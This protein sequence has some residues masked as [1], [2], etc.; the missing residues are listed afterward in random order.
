[1]NRDSL[2]AYLND[3]LAIDNF[4]DY[5]VNGLQVEGKP[6]VL[7]IAGGVSVS[8]RFIH[9]AIDWGADL[10]LLHHGLFWKSDPYPFYLRGIQKRRLELLIKND[11]NLVAYHLPLDAHDRLG[12]NIQIL[13]KLDLRPVEPLEVGFIGT[14]REPLSRDAF[15]A[16][17]NQKLMCDAAPF[18]YGPDAIQT[19]LVI[20]GASSAAYQEAAA[21]GV[22][23]FV[24]G[25]IREENVR[26]IEEVQLNYIAAGHYNTERFGVQALL[27][28]LTEKFDLE[29]AFFEIPNPI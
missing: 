8:Q 28:H 21:R 1:M 9:Q 2:I 14:F 16:L 10:V 25:D 7:K 23:A 4:Q 6:D 20:S 27:N 19:V 15:L 12:N 17:V 13:Q 22:D 18:F 5:C 26:G 11:L 3:L 29:T 24:G